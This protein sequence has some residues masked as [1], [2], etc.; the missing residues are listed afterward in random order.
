MRDI[1][2]YPGIYKAIAVTLCLM[3]YMVIHKAKAADNSFEKNIKTT[4]TISY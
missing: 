1:N 2:F 3:L 4:T